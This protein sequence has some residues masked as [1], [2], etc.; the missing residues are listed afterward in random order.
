APGIA[1]NADA[2]LLGLGGVADIS[3]V[4]CS[5]CNELLFDPLLDGRPQSGIFISGLLQEPTVDAILAMLN[6][7]AEASEDDEDDDEEDDAA[8]CN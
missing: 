2:L 6:R 8:V 3:Y 1:D 5:G 7:D 4:S